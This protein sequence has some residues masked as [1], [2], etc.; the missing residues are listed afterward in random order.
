MISMKVKLLFV[1][2]VTAISVAVTTGCSKRVSSTDKV[3]EV[4]Q[5][6]AEMN[7]AIAKARSLLPQFWQTFEKPQKGDSDFGLKVKITEGEK[8][9]HFWTTDIERKDGKIFGVIN[10]DPETVHNV[11]LGQK[12][13]IAEADISDWMYM[14]GGKIVGNFTMRALF[15]KMSAEEVEKFK[16]MLADP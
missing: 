13:T 8:A 16:S 9:E 6:D 2:L 11:K 14:R 3:V 1:I 15:S 12:I 4:S 5:D 7:Q 10:N